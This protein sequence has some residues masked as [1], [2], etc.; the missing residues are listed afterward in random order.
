[1]SYSLKA[2]EYFSPK[3]LNEVLEILCIEENAVVFAGG[4]DILI[5]IKEGIISPKLLLDLKKIDELW[6]FSFEHDKGLTIG[7]TNTLN[8]ILESHVVKKYFPILIECCLKIGNH[9]LRNKATLVGNICSDFP[10]A[11]S[12]FA[13]FLHD[14][15]VEIISK[16]GRKKVGLSEL[17]NNSGKLNLKKEEIITKVFIPYKG[18]Y[19]G[20]YYRSLK[21]FLVPRA[22]FGIAYIKSKDL[23]RI[24]IGNISS[25]IS[26]FSSPKELKETLQTVYLEE[27][28]FLLIEKV[29]KE[30]K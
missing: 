1:M 26:L 5:K 29:V 12:L 14:A 21:R 17:F 22:S 24:A 6:L 27:E 30:L 9:E 16:E 3:S 23:T 19:H 8:E 25:K 4:T 7:A 11:D 2:F 15:E 13:L 28:E 10:V 20:K 18:E